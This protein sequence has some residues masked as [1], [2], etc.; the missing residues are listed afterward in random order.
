MFSRAGKRAEGVF[1]SSQT[2]ARDC[3]GYSGS[4]YFLQRLRW[5]P[6]QPRDETGGLAQP[7]MMHSGT[8]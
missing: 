5:R 4:P 7:L 2:V 1:F 3:T 6:H 8:A